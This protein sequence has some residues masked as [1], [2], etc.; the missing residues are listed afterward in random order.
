METFVNTV[1]AKFFPSIQVKEASALSGGLIHQTLLIKTNQ[2][3]FV[4]QKINQHV[5]KNIKALLKN[6]QNVIAH[7]QS[8]N[9]PTI[10]IIKTMSN[11]DF[12][13]IEKDI[14][15]LS[16]YIPSINIRHV[17]KELAGKSGKLLAQFHVA[18]NDFP[19]HELQITIPDFHNTEKRF[20][21]LQASILSAPAHRIP[22]GK[23]TYHFLL[24]NYCRIAPVVSAINSGEIPVRVVHNDT[25][26]ENILF[27]AERNP[28]CWI[29][30]D[31]LMPGT[32]LHDIGDAMRSGSNT[33][34]ENE[35]DLSKV[36]FDKEVYE[37]FIAS[38]L[39][40]AQSILSEIELKYIHASL[41]IILFEQ[42]CRFLEDYFNKDVY[43]PVDYSDHN[44]IR[45]N[46]QVKLLQEVMGLLDLRTHLPQ[47][48]S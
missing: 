15:Q 25:K 40:N 44:L 19:I 5:F 35:K 41:P 29:D 30:F 28:I 42:A 34:N 21:N 12:C 24:G 10:R 13:Q 47:A 6:K 22:A 26:I 32:I 2:G 38:Y 3:D 45:A 17:S 18:L 31:T 37:C 8:K 36:S 33:S 7:L 16:E 20:L 46:T 27:D 11:E 9:I 43:Y 39:E 1:L 14:W 48:K 23:P 4:L